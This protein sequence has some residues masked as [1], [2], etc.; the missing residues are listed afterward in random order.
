VHASDLFTSAP[1]AEDMA[2]VIQAL[3]VGKVDLYGDSYGS[4]FAQVFASRFPHLLRSVILDST[5]QTV[6]L[7]PWYRSTI[8]AMGANFNAACERW[9]ACA[10]AAPGSSWERI[11]AL[12][13]RLQESLIAGTVP[14]PDGT[15][16]R[17]SM[18]VVGLVDL[19]NDA[20]GDPHIYREID[21]AA[22][23]L[24][25]GGEAAPLLRLYDQR[26]E[27]DESYFTSK[28]GE[29]SAE[30]YL[31]VSCLD[32]PQLF[33]MASPPSVRATELADAEALLPASTFAPFSTEEWL[34]QDQNTEA[35][36]ACLDWPAPV[37]AEPPTLGK[38]PLISSAL[39]VLVL[40][41]EFDTWTPPAEVHDVLAEL[42]GHSR[43]IELANATHV[44]G[45]GDTVC[46]S[47]LVQAFVQRPQQLD[48]LDASCAPAVPPIHTVGLFPLQL[49]EEPPIEPALGNTA[50]TE[51][52]RLAAAAV[53]T[54]GDAVA[55]YQAIEAEHDH[56]LFGGSVTATRNGSLLTLADDRLIEGVAVGGTVRLSPSPIPDDGD[57]AVATLTATAPGLSKGSFTAT[58]T[59]SGAGAV[60]QITGS[61]GRETLAGTLPAP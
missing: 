36:T 16:Q 19:L 23:A 24:T 33:N 12:A 61:V 8:D 49:Q 25:D 52:L 4:F 27:E 50:S 3:Q 40:G 55:R 34:S 46:G 26:L 21:A 43:F 48:S 31:A 2:A 41:G 13:Q 17:V 18:G 11:A 59:T 20:A 60:T 45:E 35:Y 6:G 29:Y 30:L 53:Q 54:A 38:L 51:D 44:V 32:Y 10:Q 58:W 5:Y 37:E 56:G 28:P 47:E 57:S 39:P 9:P 15:L 22:R 1:A 7:D 14:G 42:G